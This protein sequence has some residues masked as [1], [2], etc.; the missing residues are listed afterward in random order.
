MAEYPYLRFFNGVENELNLKEDIVSGVLKGSIFLPE[1]STG[2]YESANLFILEEQK[3]PQGNQVWGTPISHAGTSSGTQFKVEWIENVYSSS[4]I[5]FYGTKLENETVKIQELDTLT[6]DTLD[7][8]NLVSV[9]S[10]GL[11]EVSSHINSAMQVNIGLSS[12]NEGRHDK[13][14]RIS[15]V[16]DGTVLAE[17]LV[18]GETVGEDERLRDLLQNLGASLDDGDFIMFKEHDIN[19]YG[20]DWQL[21]NQKRRELLLE[22]HNIKPFVG[23]YKAV[24]NAIDFFGYNNITLKE[25]WLNINQDSAAF[26]KLQAVPVPDTNSGFSYKK[27]KKFNLPSS[28]LKKTS[29]FSLVYKLNNPTG[30]FDIWDIPEVKESFDFTPEEVLIKLYGLKG[31]LQK[32][33][34]PL[35]AKIIDITGEGDFFDQKNINTWNNQEPIAVFNEGKD[36][37]FKIHPEDKQLYIEDYKLISDSDVLISS[38]GGNI[39]GLE[40]F[41]TISQNNRELLI[42][43]FEDFYLKYYEENKES[44]NN[45]VLGYYDIPVGSPLILECTSLPQTWEDADFCWLDAN[46]NQI[47]WNNWWKRN[48]YEIEWIVTGPKD[49]SQSFKGDI[50]YWETNGLSSPN[51]ELTWHPEMLKLAI[52]VPYTGDYHVELRLTD[53]N[54][55]TSFHKIESFFHIDVKPIELYGVY[56]WKENTPWRKWKTS[57]DKSGGYWNLPTENLEEVRDS[58]QSLYL[59]MDRSNYIN[60]ESQGKQFSTVRRFIDSDP[61]NLTGYDETTGPYTWDAIDEV[62]WNDFKHC[63]WNSTRIGSDLASSFK[64]STAFQGNVLTISHFDPITKETKIGYHTLVSSTPSGSNDISGWQAIADELN[65]SDDEIISKFNYNPVFEDTNNDGNV[66]T[67]NFII[68]VGKNYSYSYDFNDVYLSIGTGASTGLIMG[69]VHFTPY[70]PTF[71]SVR[72]I[73]GCGDIERSTHVTLSVDKTQMPG[74][75]NPIWKIYKDT[76]ADFSDIYYDNMWLP[77]IFQEPGSYRISLELEDSNGNKNSIE[78]NMINVK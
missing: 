71:D 7:H 12:E 37:S 31:K 16:S 58:F 32:D 55:F 24:L 41:D 1:V 69:E 63:W 19:E 3:D 72:I 65:L 4:D 20:I 9:D 68:C 28:N 6:L 64:I 35:Q 73:N 14:L 61:A 77:Y 38:S 25:Y 18:Y 5:F 74:I 26:G 49:Y 42:S 33:Y 47:T 44:F 59:T 22:L 66:D 39:I 27:R 30:E 76:N 29:R 23:T 45:S 43:E 50:G 10:T 34:L 70:N 53:L 56:Q 2:L 78:R 52:I 60:D 62:R 40:E 36:V 57:W 13:S 51:E 75:K 15:D 48:V 8:T 54:G 46:D 21:M 11:K 67:F 17:I